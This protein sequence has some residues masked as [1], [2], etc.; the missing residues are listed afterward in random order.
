MAPKCLILLVGA[1]GFEPPTSCSQSRRAARLRHAPIRLLPLGVNI[2][3]YLFVQ[4]VQAI[5]PDEIFGL[6]PVTVNKVFDARS[7]SPGNF[8]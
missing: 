3:L 2:T 4:G 6:A 1:R 7:D 8:A 5:Y